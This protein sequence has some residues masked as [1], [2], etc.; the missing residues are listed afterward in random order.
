MRAS[1]SAH[2]AVLLAS[3][4]VLAQPIDEKIA[5]DVTDEK[6]LA[7]KKDDAEDGWKLK[8]KVGATGAYNHS[9]NVV[10]AVDGSTVQLGA[11]IDFTADLIVGQH[12]WENAIS[13]KENQSRTPQIS[14]FIKSADELSLKTTYIYN[15][16]NPAWLGF[17]G[18][19]ALN[20]Q[21]FHG[22]DIRPEAVTIVRTL[23][24]GTAVTRAVAPQVR[25]ALTKPFEPLMLKESAG[26]VAKPVANDTITFKAKVGAGLQHVFVGDGFSAAD[27][28]ATPELEF[29]QLEDSTQIGALVDLDANGKIADN[30]TWSA[31]ASYF[32]PFAGTE[33][34]GVEGLAI[35]SVEL[36]AKLAVKLA[37]WVSLDYVLSAK[38]L[39]QIVDEWQVANGVTVT[40]G[41]D[42]I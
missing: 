36:G 35:S 41:F 20:T 28:E 31:N 12:T 26:A 25:F 13:L 40:V 27:D 14:S 22:Y 10:G 32:Y 2:L 30:I 15:L 3:A 19:A 38:Y 17:F 9:M 34:D 37:E 21:L 8:L 1:W 29:K 6:V 5:K 18:R 7:E 16:V 33:I 24:D 23:R 39:P 4:T 42:L 11:L